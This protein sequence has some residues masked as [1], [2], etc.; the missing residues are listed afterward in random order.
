MRLNQERSRIV[1]G[2]ANHRQTD[3]QSGQSSTERRLPPPRAGN[4]LAETNTSILAAKAAK[5]N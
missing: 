2:V 3:W 1:N 5:A 4:G